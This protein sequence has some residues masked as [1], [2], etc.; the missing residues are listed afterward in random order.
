MSTR[1]MLALHEG[2]HAA[3][4]RLL[5]RPV[6]A[7]AIGPN[8]GGAEVGT[9]KPDAEPSLEQVVDELTILA[10]GRV[11]SRGLPLPLPRAGDDADLARRVASRI[12]DSPDEI[13]ALVQ[14]GAAR[15]RAMAERPEFIAATEALSRAL[16]VRGELSAQAVEAQLS[17]ALDFE[18]GE[19][20]E[21]AA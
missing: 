7:I 18:N 10:I 8:G 2:A 17:A 4:A 3:A 15:A 13:S 9:L 12:S 14:L 1:E 16:I 5:G 19:L 20:D 21:Q 6:G 11:L